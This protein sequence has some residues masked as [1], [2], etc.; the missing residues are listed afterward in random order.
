MM[1]AFLVLKSGCESLERNDTPNRQQG[2][3]RNLYL[4][5]L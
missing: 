4:D 5:N 2:M 1:N 3:Q